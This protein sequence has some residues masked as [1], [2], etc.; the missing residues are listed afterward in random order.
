MYSSKLAVYVIAYKF[1]SKS[2]ASMV[3]HATHQSAWY[4]MGYITIACMYVHAYN[5]DII[6]IR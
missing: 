2:S 1:H 6:C 3:S 5:D 4:T